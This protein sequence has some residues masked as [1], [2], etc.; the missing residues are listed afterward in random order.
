VLE[1]LRVTGV[2]AKVEKMQAE[3]ASGIKRESI[4]ASELLKRLE[5]ACD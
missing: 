3:D 2:L 4:S 1:H 5:S